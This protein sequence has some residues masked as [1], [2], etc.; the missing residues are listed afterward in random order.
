MRGLI[1]ILLA[2]TF[3]LSLTAQN[4]L[5][6]ATDTE[7]GAA[8]ELAPSTLRN[9]QWRGESPLFTYQDKTTLYQQSVENSTATSII[10]LAEINE[11]IKTTDTLEVMPNITWENE[12]EF[13]FFTDKY[14]YN[15]KAPDKTLIAS[16]QLP[17]NAENFRLFY[18]KKL[19]AYTIRNNVFVTGWNISPVQLTFDNN[20]DIVNGDIV[21]RNEFG[22]TQGLFWSPQGNYLA[23]YR[24][25]NR[26]VGNYPLVDIMAR[27]GTAKNIMYPMAG[28]SSEH[29]SLGVYKIANRSVVFIEKN[30]T[31]SEKYLTNITWGPD[32]RNIYIQ[33]LNRQQNH[34]QFNKY[35]VSNGALVKTLF[36]EKHGK[37]VEPLNSVIFLKSNPQAFIYQTR[38]NG[39]NHA[40]LY[41]T[42]GKLIRQ[43]TDGK[44]EITGILQLSNDDKLYYT[45]TEA[46]PLETNAYQLDIKS[47][48]TI[49]LTANPGVHTVLVSSGGKCCIDTYSNTTTP[50]IIDIITVSGKLKR[51]VLKAANPLTNFNMPEMTI[52]TI[53]AADGVTDLYYRL[54]KPAN[55]DSTKKY[56]AIVYVYGGPHEQLIENRWLGGARLWDYMMAQKGYLMLTV[57]NRGSMN[58]GLEFENVIHRQCGVV[59]MQ[60]QREGVKFLEELGYVDMKR[61]GVHGWSYGGFMTTSLMVTYPDIFKVGVAGGPVI[62]WKYYEVMYGERYMDTPQENPEGYAKT[63]L[64]PKAKNLKGKLLLVHGAQDPTVVWQ[65][66]LVF[67]QECIKNQIPVD[68]FVY[69]LAEHNVRGYDRIHLMEK[70]TDYFVKNL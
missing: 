29:V 21:S 43:L 10:S 26:N 11:I 28:M 51:N 16:V 55:F 66:S 19:I 31:V 30:D 63:A 53:K 40:Y 47:G 42:G 25:D 57:D 49:R 32:E 70:V 52:G 41:N 4:R 68:Y 36:E 37:Y 50:R 14:W 38:R 22:I 69:P 5:L 3:S 15:I 54:I 24:K 61:I 7:V 39:Y 48:K 45:S 17:E 33:V 64:P 1:S 18:S 44:W 13:H 27:E 6:T 8:R 12:S 59:E 58:R 23:F 2:I 46:S 35:N 60:D 9:L 34:M 67:I 65:N 20:P 56:P 62:D